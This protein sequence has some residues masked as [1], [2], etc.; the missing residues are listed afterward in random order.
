MWIPKCLCLLLRLA[1]NR[2]ETELTH[3]GVNFNLPYQ[4]EASVDEGKM[5]SVI[6][7]NYSSRYDILYQ[8]M[9]IFQWFHYSPAA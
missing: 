4:N 8:G 1:R 3:Y 2:D 9:C 6:N 5:R 7:G